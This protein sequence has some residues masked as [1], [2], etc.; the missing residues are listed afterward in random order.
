MPVIPALSTQ[1]TEAG[2]EHQFGQLNYTNY[3][4]Y[5]SKY[6]AMVKHYKVK[7]KAKPAN[8][9]KISMVTKLYCAQ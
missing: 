1:K 4:Y 8:L 5:I 3:T 6:K 2:V 9:C 7:S